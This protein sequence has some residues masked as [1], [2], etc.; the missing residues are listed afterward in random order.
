MTGFVSVGGGL[1]VGV[2][3]LGVGP[4]VGVDD[5]GV[6]LGVGVDDLAGRVGLVGP[7]VEDLG[8]GVEDLVGLVV[9]LGTEFEF[10]FE[11]GLDGAPNVGL[12]VGVAGLPVGVAGLPVGVAG[13]EPGP[14]EEVGLRGPP[15]E[16][17]N[18]GDDNGCLDSV[19]L[20]LPFVSR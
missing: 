11:P 1:R 9:V 17:F 4:L 12:P 10:E 8:V 6:D 13:L 19:M 3:A 5:L 20:F 14:L 15:L 2:G 7:M 18:P 16:V